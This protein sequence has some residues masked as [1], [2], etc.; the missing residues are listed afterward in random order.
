MDGRKYSIDLE[1]MVQTNLSTENQRSVRVYYTVSCYIIQPDQAPR[2]MEFT[3]AHSN[4]YADVYKARNSHCLTALSAVVAKQTGGDGC[5]RVQQVADE[6]D[7]QDQ[8]EWHRAA[9]QH[10][11]LLQERAASRHDA[12]GQRHRQAQNANQRGTPYALELRAVGAHFRLCRSA[13]RTRST[14]LRWTRLAPSSV[15]LR[16]QPSCVSPVVAADVLTSQVGLLKIGT[17]HAGS[18]CGRVYHQNVTMCVHAV[19]CIACVN[20]PEGEQ[21]SLRFASRA[22]RVTAQALVIAC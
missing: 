5:A 13:L 2:T 14:V 7:A 19:G 21:L 3:V 1:R 6:C 10:A 4:T 17:G 22:D 9:Q 11:E 18:V 8:L 12:H 15:R 20:R 16:C